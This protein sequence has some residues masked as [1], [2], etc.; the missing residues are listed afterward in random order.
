MKSSNYWLFFSCLYLLVSCKKADDSMPSI[1][2]QEEQNTLAESA[3]PFIQ[4]NTTV[5][6]ENEPKVPGRMS[7]FKNQEEQLSTPIGIEYRGSTSFR[8]SEKKSFGIETWD[9]SNQDVKLSVLD[10]PEE[11]DWI[12]NGHVYNASNQTVIDRTLMHHYSAYSLSRSMGRY[13]SRSTFVELELNGDF[14]GTYVFMEK[15][16]RDKNRIDISKLS[17]SDNSLPELS[18]GYILKIDKTSGGDVASGQPLSYYLT[19]WDDDARYSEDISFRSHYDVEGNAIDFAPFDPPY[20][21]NQY[22][23]TYFLYE[24]PKASKIS[25]KQK[26]YIQNYIHQFETALL[27]DDF[28]T[29]ERS[30]L[31][32]IDLDSF[33]DYF[34]LNELTGNIDAYRLSTYLHK[35]RDGLLTMGPIWDHNIGY[36][37]QD[38]V[39][40]TAWIAH[41]NR[42]VE[43]DAWLVPF[44]WPR[45]L[46]DPFFQQRLKERW[47]NFRSN[48]LATS[49]VLDLVQTTADY[50]VDNGAVERNYNTWS[51]ITI[52]YSQAIG[53]LKDYL[54]NRLVWMDE[55]INAF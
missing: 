19:N 23:E 33:V 21:Q 3:L 42:Y 48:Q 39:P 9:E 49:N 24:Y 36:N 20:H 14:M 34:I 44:W 25:S 26:E 13:A 22:L 30:Y 51:G 28:S 40:P 41:Y 55:Q 16:K 29:N 50:L 31:N 54:E 52:N 37:R 8:L 32:Y 53:E 43:Q 35:D 6:I 45:L 10:F 11:E 4:I 15:L 1:D 12:L 27:T 38:R 47:Q 46:Q 5:D 18:G 7:V 17:S 2:E